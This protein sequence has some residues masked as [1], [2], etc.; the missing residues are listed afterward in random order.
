LYHIPE[1]EPISQAK[2]KG[3]RQNDKKTQGRVPMA[4]TAKRLSNPIFSR[5]SKGAKT[6]E[7]ESWAGYSDSA[8]RHSIDA[9]VLWPR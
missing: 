9:I 4:G 6:N 1:V 5:E 3:V 8:L 7:K 2:K